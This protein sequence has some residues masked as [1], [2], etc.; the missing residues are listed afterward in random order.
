MKVLKKIG[1]FITG[2]ILGII[3]G[4]IIFGTTGV[5][6]AIAS[7]AVQYTNN[8]QSTVEGALNDLYAKANTWINPT[9]VQTNS[10]GKMFA[11]SRGVIFRRNESTHFFKLNNWNVEKTHI[12]QVFSDGWCDDTQ[13]DRIVCGASDFQCTVFSNGDVHC[14]EYSSSSVCYLSGSGEFLCTNY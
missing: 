14:A 8:G 13:S 11:S 4:G 7:N 2:N 9:T 1:K 10:S 6:A 5:L 12:Q 3:I